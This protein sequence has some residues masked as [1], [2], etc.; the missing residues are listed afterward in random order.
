MASDHDVLTGC[1]GGDGIHWCRGSIRCLLPDQHQSLPIHGHQDD[2]NRGCGPIAPLIEVIVF[3]LFTH[4]ANW[5]TSNVF[6]L[7]I[8]RCECPSTLGLIC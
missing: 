1:I 7:E 5:S 2:L 8:A 4:V 3:G 6:K